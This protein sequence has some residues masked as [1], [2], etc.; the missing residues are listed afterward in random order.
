M[1]SSLG[2]PCEIAPIFADLLL[3]IH[4]WNCT[5]EFH[6]LAA[7]ILWKAIG[8]HLDCRRTFTYEKVPIGLWVQE[9]FDLARN[10]YDR[11]GHFV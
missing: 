8:S 5:S 10:D 9:W 4:A 1:K 11:L 7:S 3:F 2:R 6:N